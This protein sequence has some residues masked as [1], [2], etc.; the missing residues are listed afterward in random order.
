M[1]RFRKPMMVQAF[2]T[3]SCS[4]GVMQLAICSMSAV[5]TVAG[6]DPNFQ[7][8]NKNKQR[9]VGFRVCS[10]YTTVAIMA[11]FCEPSLCCEQPI[12]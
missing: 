7:N 10:M 2:T 8:N 3:A 5:V 4:L 1:K 11:L 6:T 12:S 9:L